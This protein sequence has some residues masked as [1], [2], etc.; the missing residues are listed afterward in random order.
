MDQHKPQSQTESES[1][2]TH[3]IANRNI[4]PTLKADL[5]S[6]KL[7]KE[8]EIKI[9]TTAE[10][11]NKL[12][13]ELK[14]PTSTTTNNAEP[15][16][17][18]LLK[19]KN[20]NAEFCNKSPPKSGHTNAT[21]NQSTNNID[22]NN[23]N[24]NVG[25]PIHPSQKKQLRSVSV[26][27]ESSDSQQQVTSIR[28]TNESS[29]PST[30]ELLENTT[31]V[32]KRRS[33][34]CQTQTNVDESTSMGEQP[35]QDQL[36]PSNG[37]LSSATN[38]QDSVVTCSDS[39]VVDLASE[40]EDVEITFSLSTPPSK[41][42]RLERQH[43]ATTSRVEKRS[44]EKVT[45][46]RR[47]NSDGE[48]SATSK[49]SAPNTLLH[50][51]SLLNTFPN[52]ATANNLGAQRTQS[53]SNIALNQSPLQRF[54]QQQQQST[55]S[56][57]RQLNPRQTPIAPTQASAVNNNNNTS[58]V[59]KLTDR[60]CNIC[61][62]TFP[63]L[64]L[65][66]QHMKKVHNNTSTSSL[67]SPV[68]QNRFNLQNRSTAPIN[69]NLNDSVVSNFNDNTVTRSPSS[70][71]SPHQGKSS[72]GSEVSCTV[73]FGLFRNNRDLKSHML[74]H[75]EETIHK[76]EICLKPFRHK[77]TLHQ[78]MLIHSEE[79]PHECKTCGKRFRQ[80]GHLILHMGK[81]S[82]DNEGSLNCPYCHML[83]TD[84]GEFRNHIRSHE[85]E[86]PYNCNQC[87]E[88]FEHKGD[89]MKHLEGHNEGRPF[90][91]PICKKS[92]KTKPYLLGHMQM[93][94]SNQPDTPHHKQQQKEQQP[95]HA[96][97]PHQRLSNNQPKIPQHPRHKKMEVES[98]STKNNISFSS[99]PPAS[100][101]QQQNDVHTPTKG[102]NSKSNVSKTVQS[103]T[104]KTLADD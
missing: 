63:N 86:L 15:S 78:H 52:S 60:T 48:H 11:I 13:Q 18:D 68:N 55:T 94:K 76:C 53:V 39:N 64:T 102:T 75:T 37:L 45:S 26:G 35:Q 40:E 56:S 77:S 33:V 71:R 103:V 51:R 61:N 66:R 4:V 31:S 5:G 47:R 67:S 84:T 1:D 65:A 22:N 42:Q 14:S 46:R 12:K 3:Y 29:H 36:Q 91:C 69:N 41:R 99:P 34:D 43:P 97:H 89:L 19:T 96:L 70:T 81:H 50:P 8:L 73:C 6:P 16:G 23:R 93:H 90:C 85:A 72:T 32:S 74:L 7:P 44:R 58:N 20:S 27:C 98:P 28:R 95:L 83:Y 21:H 2:T 62:H 54:N 57:R 17:S 101:Y 30:T 92:F 82:Q 79:M 49:N 100:L 88:R 104:I 10:N 25:R 9:P 87:L 59:S 80:Q 24:K 38:H